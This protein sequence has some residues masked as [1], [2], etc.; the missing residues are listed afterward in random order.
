MHPL[1]RRQVFWLATLVVIWAFFGLVGRDVWKAEEAHSLGALLDWRDHG[2]LF[3]ALAAPL[4]TLAAN[5]SAGLSAP[6]FDYLDGARLVSGVFTLLALLFTGLAARALFGPGHEAAAAL[7]MMGCL[8]MILRAHALLPETAMIAAYALLILGLTQTRDNAV[9]GGILLALAFLALALLRGW[10]DLLAG[11]L[12]VA[13]TLLSREWRTR[14]MRIGLTLGLTLAASLFL[15]VLLGGGDAEAWW[16]LGAR[17]IATPRDVGDLFADLGWIAWPVWPLALWA[18]W[19]DHRR[20]GREFVLHPVMAASL[21]LLIWALWPAYTREGGLMPLLVP[22][23]LLA[24]RGLVSLKR[25]AAQ[26]LY[27]FG[28]LTFLFFALMFWHYYGAIDWG[29]P[30]RAAQHM[31]KLTPGYRPGAITAPWLLSA[32]LATLLWLVAIPLFPR[33]KARPVLVWATGM[34][35]AWLVVFSLFRSW[36]DVGW[37]YTPMLR[38]ISQRVPVS[39]CLRAEVD[40]DMVAML[41]YRMPERYRAS[42]QC[43][44]WLIAGMPKPL[45]IEGKPLRLLWSGSRPRYKRDVHSLYGVDHD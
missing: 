12:I 4:Y 30:S 24:A 9:S 10:L 3:Q 44:Y 41:R 32:A 14:S 29:W 31:A 25:G 43:D 26:A 1:D 17:P 45:Q 39:A 19:Y 40:P 36:A 28:V 22:L 42:G 38:E 23:A 21:I 27:W 2:V 18:V 5:V 15:A 6:W 33:A 37:G 34:A 35:M 7:A 13:S 11:L 16:R 20:L 8:G